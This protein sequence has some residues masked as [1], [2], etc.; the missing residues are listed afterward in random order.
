MGG[1]TERGQWLKA[2]HQFL[3]RFVLIDKAVGLLALAHLVQIIYLIL[4]NAVI[5][6]F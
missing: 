4:S 6:L 3:H 2:A 1:A 5:V